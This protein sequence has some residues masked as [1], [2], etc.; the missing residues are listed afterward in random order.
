M[1]RV[2]D[3]LSDIRHKRGKRRLTDVPLMTAVLVT[4]CCERTSRASSI[5]S[6]VWTTR[7]AKNAPSPVILLRSTNSGRYRRNQK[8]KR[9]D[10]GIAGDRGHQ[11]LLRHLCLE[12]EKRA[13]HGPAPSIASENRKR[14]GWLISTKRGTSCCSAG[15]AAGTRICDTKFRDLCWE[16]GRGPG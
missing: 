12:D 1:A 10:A 15:A 13:P 6:I 8:A 14:S 4:A 2:L 11:G 5:C 16:T 9:P 7:R 3:A